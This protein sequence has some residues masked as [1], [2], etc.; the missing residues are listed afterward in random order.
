MENKKI[1]LGFISGESTIST[2]TAI[3]I[4]I[5]CDNL[6]H[7]DGESYLSDSEYDALYRLTKTSKPSDPYFLSVGS[8]VRGDAV[9]L[10]V[11]MPS[12]DQ[13][14]EGEIE[15]WIKKHNLGDEEII[16][17]DKMDGVSVCLVYGHAGDFQIAYTRGDGF[18]GHD[19]TR[20]IKN[21]KSVPKSVSGAMIVRAEIEFSESAFERVKQTC[22]KSDGTPYKNSRNACAGMMNKD[23]THDDVV[24]DNLSVF[25]YEIMETDMNKKDQILKLNEE[26][27]EIAKAGVFKGKKLTDD[28][29]STYITDRKQHIDFAMDGVVIDINDN[30]VRKK[31]ANSKKKDDINPAYSVK[32]KV[33][34]TNNIVEAIVESV[35]WNLSK[36]G[37]AKPTIK[38]TPFELQQVTISNTT[39]FNAKYILDNNIGNGTIV[40][41]TRSGDVIPY[42]L[43]VVKSTKA[44]MPACY[45]DDYVWSENEVDLILKNMENTEVKIKQLI[46]WSTS[47]DIPS[48]KEGTIRQ[49]FENGFE[50]PESIIISNQSDIVSIVGKNGNKIYKGLRKILTD[51]EPEK[52]FGSHPTFGVGLGVR[53]FKALFKSLDYNK[54]LDDNHPFPWASIETAEGFNTKTADKVHDGIGKFKEFLN[55]IEGYYSFKTISENSV[56]YFTDKNICFTG[57]REKEWGDIIEKQGGKVSSSVSKNTDMLVAKDI[58]ETSG[59]IQKAKDLGIKTISKDD[60][61]KLLDSEP[62]ISD[63]SEDDEKND[64]FDFE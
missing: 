40:K 53:K 61:E 43:E 10:P 39:G 33:L 18:E 47:L 30:S 59:K 6:Y 58:S 41:M 19:I 60:F 35:E 57:F 7:N 9:K 15:P 21:I 28:F 22:K 38:L 36:H 46:A 5:E 24:Y 12:L 62:Q 31:M 26:G 63:N 25:T 11:V 8:E 52:L 54:L 45:E 64:F 49:L 20:H 2:D 16:I 23:N 51:I 37:Y 4:L 34:D 44:E 32:Y 56:G 27:F 48:L 55:S 42:I 17:T 1:A 50:T 29:L 3:C 13:V 14:H